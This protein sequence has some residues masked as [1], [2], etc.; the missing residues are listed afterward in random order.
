[1]DATR[2]PLA[3]Y[4]TPNSAPYTTGS[5]FAL[6]RH[7]KLDY[8]MT[9]YNY[10]LKITGCESNETTVRTRDFCGRGR[11]PNEQQAVNKVNRVRKP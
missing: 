10:A 4:T 7:K 8:S 5:C 6:S 1:M 2:R 3:V 9:S 11:S